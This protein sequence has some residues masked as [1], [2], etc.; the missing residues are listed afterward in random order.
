ML[1]TAIALAVVTTGSVFIIYDKLPKR[2]KKFIVKHSLMSDILAFI[3]VYFILGGTL[4]ALLAAA[5]MGVFISIMLHVANNEE[6]YLYLYDLR[7]M[8]KEKLT[9]AKE[10]L[11]EYGA[12]Y[13]KRRSNETSDSRAHETHSTI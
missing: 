5:I 6:D 11:N 13:R 3:A 7:N 9:S 10:V 2:V 4:T 8:L 12:M 1:S